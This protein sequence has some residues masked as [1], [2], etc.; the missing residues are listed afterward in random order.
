VDFRRSHIVGAELQLEQ[1]S[2]P[3]ALNVGDDVATLWPRLH[4][5]ADIQ[6]SAEA[7]FAVLDRLAQGDVPQND[8]CSRRPLY[9][10]VKADS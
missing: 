5:D 3:A 6:I 7:V 4:L 2:K 1:G 9:Q 8:C 10:P